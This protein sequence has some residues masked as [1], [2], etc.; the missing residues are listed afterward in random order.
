M[1]QKYAPKGDDHR[2]LNTKEG[3]AHIK[4]ALNRLRFHKS[5]STIAI[6]NWTVLQLHGTISKVKVIKIVKLVK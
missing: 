6:I 2:R 5:E 4:G 3:T 1:Q